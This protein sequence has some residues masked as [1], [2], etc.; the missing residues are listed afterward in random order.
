MLRRQQGNVLIVLIF[1]IVVMGFLASSLTRVNWSNSD[2]FTRE[3]LGTQAWLLAHSANELALAKMYP[4]GAES[5]VSG[6]CPTLTSDT[7]FAALTNSSI[8]VSVTT[9]CDNSVGSLAGQA[10]YKIQSRVVCGSGIHQ[11]ERV[12]E[13]WVKEQQ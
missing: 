7:D 8:C 4:L 2:S 12:Q 13:V 5:N 9:Q 11:I 6:V 10:F 1:V 3:Q